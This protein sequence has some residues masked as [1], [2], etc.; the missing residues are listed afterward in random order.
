VSLP[1]TPDQF[2]GIF[3]DYNRQFWVAVVFWWLATVGALVLVWRRPSRGAFLPYFLGALWL[4]NA[5]AYHAYLFTRI[6][7]AAWLFSALFAIQGVLFVWSGA[8]RNVS[9]LSDSG[10]SQ[11]IG[12]LLIAYSLAYPLLTIVSGH[13]YPA[14]PTFGVPCPTVILTIGLLLTVSGGIPLSLGVIPVAWGFIG[15]SAAV[16]LAVVTDYV[17]FAAGLLL[18]VTLVAQRLSQRGV[19]R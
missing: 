2:F 18:L 7:P 9:Y 13:S 4:W 11:T 19:A 1:F 6:N 15:G 12:L 17:L 14:A 3:A 5:A 8:R 16:F 10:S